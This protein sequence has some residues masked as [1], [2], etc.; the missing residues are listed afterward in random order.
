VKFAASIWLWGAGLSL[1]VLLLL[2]LG[3]LA[4]QRAVRRFG[5]ESL[6]S[7]LKTART[8]P[9]RALRGV[10]LVTA[11]ALAFVAAAQPQYGRG[12]RLVPATNL[13]VVLVL[14]FSK[15][16]YARDISPSRIDRA[17]AEMGNLVRQLAPA[18]FGAVAF[19]GS[20]MTFPLTSDGAAVAQFFRGL[21][22]NDMPIGGTAIGR[23]LE[24]A[25]QLLVR[26]PQSKN[27]E[28]V[29]VLV[30]D[31]EDLEGDPVSAAESI[32]GD[33]VKIHVVQ[34]GGRSPEPI[35]DVDE[36]GTVR[37][38]RTD[39][40]GQLLTT[41]LS[42]EGEAT[43]GKVA[44]KAGGTVVR[45]EKGTTGIESIT[46]ELR[47]VMTE[48]LSERVETVYADVYA[49]PL[50]LAVLL[51]VVE[52]FIGTSAKRTVISEP[53]IERKRRSRREK[54]SGTGS[55]DALRRGLGAGLVLLLGP[56]LGG[57]TEVE[58]ALDRVL[59]HHA[60]EVDDAIAALNAKQP[61]RAAELL[62]GYLETG[63]CEHG[64]I[65]VPERARKY[66]DAAFDL[67]LALFA[68]GEQFG[69][70]FGTE[71][72]A[73]AP[74]QATDPAA[75]QKTAQ[76]REHV[77]C[78]LRLVLPL[79]ENEALP[80]ELRARAHYLAGNL[81]FLRGDYEAAVKAYDAALRLEPATPAPKPDAAVKPE[82][83]PA[84]AETPGNF[85][86]NAAHNR[87]VALRRIEE[88]KQQEKQDDQKQDQKPE[89][90][91]GDEQKDQ[92]KDQQ[93]SKGEQK[94]DQK[95]GQPEDQKPGDQ[96]QQKDDQKQDQKP[97]EEPQADDQK[98]E[99]Q[100]P[101]DKASQEQKPE[102][103]QPSG[104]QG[105][106][107]PAAHEGPSVSQDDRLLDELERA[108]TVQE[109]D[110]ERSVRRGRRRAVMEDK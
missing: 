14:D 22:P 61:E 71:A 79:G 70:K 65:G 108:P 89:G 59:Q 43:L 3:G 5:E 88:K 24:A 81:E 47:R 66:A 26:D 44:S 97:G 101:G 17:K 83:K 7:A 25:H 57:C 64:V 86:R 82:E 4:H 9:R 45:S 16:M 98:P 85:E 20:T 18:R 27:H 29:I 52:S 32:G 54:R 94:D 62:Q 93:S 10:L 19:A 99:A 6:V 80:L 13:D 106:E 51:L 107:A 75:A 63:K 109:H 1:L 12:T 72:P 31:G 84:G 68:L 33:N 35:P 102:G 91:E 110:A 42:A 50:S 103:Q 60:P 38:M 41:S 2:V 87:A 92:Q 69:Q 58:G 23:A 30:T 67:G 105:Q 77:E 55:R 53:P 49:Y 78:A 8:G 76:R 90:Q 104:G 21:E 39:D 40:N 48:E 37:G 36:N 28:R 56:G 74:D 73:A 46:R 15:S 34:I 100:K 11:L 96:D 95:Q